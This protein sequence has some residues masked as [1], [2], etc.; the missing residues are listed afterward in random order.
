MHGAGS[1]MQIKFLCAAVNY[2]LTEERRGGSEKDR[3]LV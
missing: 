2:K 1:L 3:A